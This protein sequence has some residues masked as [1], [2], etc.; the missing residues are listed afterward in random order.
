MDEKK[1][2]IETQA[3]ANYLKYYHSEEKI[4]HTYTVTRKPNRTHASI[5]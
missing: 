4:S 1:R 2:D 5:I 3:T